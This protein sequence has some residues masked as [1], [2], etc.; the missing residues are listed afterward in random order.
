MSL[1]Q[2]IV[3]NVDDKN[4]KDNIGWTPLHYAAR[5]GYLSVCQ[6]I[7]ENVDNKNPKNDSG[8][9]PFDFASNQAIKKIIK[10]ALYKQRLQNSI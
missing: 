5:H 8:C 4:P 10:D 3:E 2:L 6:L 7:V 1:C 9:T